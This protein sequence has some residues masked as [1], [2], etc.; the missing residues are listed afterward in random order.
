[1]VHG[2]TVTVTRGFLLLQKVSVQSLILIAAGVKAE[3]IC[4]VWNVEGVAVG[5][6][7]L[8]VHIYETTHQYISE[9]N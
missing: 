4:S 7:K 8:L 6:S 1:M 2:L 3:F 9:N 5:F